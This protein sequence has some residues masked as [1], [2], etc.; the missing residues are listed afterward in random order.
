MYSLHTRI[1]FLL[2][3]W[4]GRLFCTV[5]EAYLLYA[6]YLQ[7]I[8]SVCMEIPCSCIIL[9]SLK[10]RLLKLYWNGDSKGAFKLAVYF[11]YLRAILYKWDGLF[12]YVFHF[13]KLVWKTKHVYKAKVTSAWIIRITLLLHCVQQTTSSWIH[14]SHVDNW[15]KNL[16]F[17]FS[18]FNRTIVSYRPL[19]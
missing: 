3:G 11:T 8:L 15:T 19:C 13:F 10:T 12:S 5:I 16:M 14:C 17:P 6:V 7:F 9:N 1:F 18:L 2:R 4:R